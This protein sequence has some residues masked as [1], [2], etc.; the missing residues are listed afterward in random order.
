MLQN[1]DQVFLTFIIALALVACLTYLLP[2]N[3]PAQHL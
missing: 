1:Y 3:S 2:L